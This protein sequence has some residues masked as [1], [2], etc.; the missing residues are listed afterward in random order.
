[1][2]NKVITNFTPPPPNIL[3]RLR[4]IKDLEINYFCFV[5]VLVFKRVFP[6]NVLTFCLR[7]RCQNRRSSLN[8]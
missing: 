6:L 8:G 2:Y 7:D 4:V 3:I 5:A 1:M